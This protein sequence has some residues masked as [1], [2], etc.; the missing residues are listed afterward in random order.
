LGK[1]SSPAVSSSTLLLEALRDEKKFSALLLKAVDRALVESLGAALT[2]VVKFYVDTTT[3][4][5]DP[6]AFQELLRRYLKGSAQ[7]S[8][9]LEN[10]IRWILGEY[11][12]IQIDQSMQTMAFPAFINKCR[13]IT[14]SRRSSGWQPAPTVS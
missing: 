4:L 10:K 2:G 13:K 6:A 12:Q 8:E 5:K 14:S 1:N 11:L 9:V 3:I 7:S